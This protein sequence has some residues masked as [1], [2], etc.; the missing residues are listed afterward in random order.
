[1]YVIFIASVWQ[2][3]R[4]RFFP[5]QSGSRDCVCTPR[6]S[7]CLAVEMPL[8]QILSGQRGKHQLIHV[9][10]K[11]HEW[12]YLGTRLL[13]NVAFIQLLWASKRLFWIMSIKNQPTRS[14][15]FLI[16]CDTCRKLQ[17]QRV[18]AHLLQ[19]MRWCIR[20]VMVFVIL[21][22]IYGAE[23]FFWTC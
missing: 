22:E 7:M 21:S 19:L 20:H 17:L 11:R 13:V 9:L 5:M 1:M 12:T 6:G 14:Q 15:H 18:V 10:W 2:P 4:R 16:F 23:Y 8:L 3:C